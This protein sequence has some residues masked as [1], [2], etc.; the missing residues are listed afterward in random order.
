MS[1]DKWQGWATLQLSA[2]GL[3][4][5]GHPP[6]PTLVADICPTCVPRVYAAVRELTPWAAL[7]HIVWGVE[8]VAEM[9]QEAPTN[10]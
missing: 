9:P 6:A 5:V 4:P 8:T 1:D 3:A 7:Q 10:G 2:T